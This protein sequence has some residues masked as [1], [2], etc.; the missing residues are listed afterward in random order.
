[1]GAI[2]FERRYESAHFHN[3][4]KG[5]ALDAQQI[6]TRLDPL[7]HHQSVFNSAIEGKSALLFPDTDEDYL[8]QRSEAT[9][10]K[11]FLCDDRWRVLTPQ[12]GTGILPEGRLIRGE[13]VLFPNLFPLAAYHAVVML[14]GRH[15]RL[16]D[17]FPPDLLRDAF[18]VSVEFI[19]R[20]HE[21]DS[22]TAYFTINANYLFPAGASVVH[23]HFQVLGSRY[24]GTHHRMLLENS[25]QYFESTGTC[26][27]TDLL[28]AEEKADARL[29]GRTGG[30]EW[31]A[32]FSPLGA[33]EIDAVWPGRRHFLEWT[34]AEFEGVA[35][36]LSRVLRA[37][38]GMKL[39]TFNLSC[40]SGPLDHPGPEFRCF[41]R[42][43]NRQNVAPHYRADDYYF[44]K[45]LRNEIIVRRPEELASFVRGYFQGLR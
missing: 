40:F 16:L 44:Q 23:P 9:K 32:A 29:I 26:Y 42:L 38:H 12:Y 27:W 24:P 34:D 22:R 3:P 43:V 21:S 2:R 37:Y 1:M 25:R 18:E 45:L 6:E 30:C 11:C 35:E 19:R 36:G 10:E 28:A 39:S 13:A 31:F 15:H 20:C 5:G 41:L 7:T 17:D 8:L 33:N 4:L 14:G